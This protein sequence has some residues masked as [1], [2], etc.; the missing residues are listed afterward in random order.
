MTTQTVNFNNTIVGTQFQNKPVVEIRIV[1]GQNEQSV[2]AKPHSAPR[3]LSAPSIVFT[4]GSVDA[5]EDAESIEFSFEANHEGDEFYDVYI[6][7]ELIGR[8]EAGSYT[9]VYVD[10]DGVQNS[11]NLPSDTDTTVKNVLTVSSSGGT[12][13]SSTINLKYDDGQTSTTMTEDLFNIPSE[14]SDSHTLALRADDLYTVRLTR[15]STHKQV[16]SWT[17]L[18]TTSDDVSTGFLGFGGPIR[19]QD[20]DDGNT[21][22]RNLVLNFGTG[23]ER[24]GSRTISGPV[25]LVYED[26]TVSENRD[27][28]M[29]FI[30]DLT[31]TS[32]F[33]LSNPTPFF[34]PLFRGGG[35][36]YRSSFFYLESNE[37]DSILANM[38]GI[39][40]TLE[41][42]SIPGT[43]EQLRFIFDKL[44][45]EMSLEYASKELNYTFNAIPRSELPEN[46][47]IAYPNGIPSWTVRMTIEIAYQR[48]I[49]R[50]AYLALPSGQQGDYADRIR[51]SQF[52]SF[53]SPIRRFFPLF[54]PP[55]HEPYTASSDFTD[56]YLPGRLHIGFTIRGNDIGNIPGDWFLQFSL[57]TQRRFPQSLTITASQT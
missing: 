53:N 31:Q 30:K 55:A 43:S 27:F 8:Y 22:Y 24:R 41:I 13:V 47:W 35:A 11:F 16:R 12:S 3:N 21:V 23:D 9:L 57:L 50:A 51:G 2:W 38:G 28:T 34:R 18:S 36:L 42:D 26:G 25:H 14:L 15:G 40:N 6:N 56:R 46:L 17:H 44:P 37:L 10:E 54:I 7:D 20:I 1:E 33:T 4:T 29:T 32:S 39:Y 52:R 19:G 49:T 5:G 48:R 45:K